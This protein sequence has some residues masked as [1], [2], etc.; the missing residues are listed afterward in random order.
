MFV[1]N[2]TKIVF[3]ELLKAGLWEQSVRL[4]HFPAIDFDALYTMADGQSVVG[5]I[6]AGFEH[7]EDMKVTKQQVL[8][9]MKKV[10]SVSG[11]RLFYFVTM[12]SVTIPPLK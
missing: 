7:L 4:A 10:F 6:A 9:F 1:N 11:M 8:P 5:L 12:L 3:F 2:N